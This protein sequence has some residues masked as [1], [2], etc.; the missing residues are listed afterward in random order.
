[1]IDRGERALSDTDIRH[2]Y[3]DIGYE[4]KHIPPITSINA[5]RMKIELE[6][7]EWISPVDVQI[8]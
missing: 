1:L 6:L 2:C 3:G 8:L 4:E 7:H 5:Y